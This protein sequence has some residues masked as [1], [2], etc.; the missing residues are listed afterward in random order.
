MTKDR[1]PL[2]QT[3]L[4][5][6]MAM[7]SATIAFSIDAMLPT[8][9]DIGAAL[10][11]VDPNR[12]QLVIG[13]FILGMG[14]GTFFTGP[15]SDAFG[16]KTIAVWGAVIY[17]LAAL[18]GAWAQDLE[19]L[20]IARFIQGI[21]AAGPRVAAMAIVRD[22]FSG[23][24]MAQILSYI[25]FVFTLAPILA[26][27]LGWAIA[28]AFGWRAIFYSFAVFSVVSMAWLI[29]RQ[30]E[31]LRPENVRPFRLGKLVSGTREVLSNRRVVK[32]TIVLTLIFSILFSALLSSQPVF[33]QVLGAG[34]TFP[35]WFGLM[36]LLAAF[37][38][39]INARV[40][41]RFGM[42]AVVQTALLVQGIFTAL[43]LLLQLT[44][45]LPDALVFPLTFLWLT[46]NFY[47]AGFG[48]GNMNA[49]AL[50]PMGHMAGLAASIVTALATIGSAIL[51]APIGQA[52][53]GTTVPLTVGVLV[54]A[55]VAWWLVGKIEDVEPA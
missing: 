19:F 41:L 33:E 4:V 43:F 44:G 40:V 38:N 24:R 18:A 29:L 5:A 23:R 12:A 31:T 42:R 45:L 2:S 55:A 10:S 3:E 20:L 6:L 34:D 35:L 27:S 28:W 49:L 26:P 32:A 52:F 53:N 21:G 36:G 8:L 54:L 50:E 37:A 14:L 22:L 15:L 11:P 17:T 25:I 39:L 30:P 16:R 9:P 48:I 7:L 1:A 13:A 51:S 47:L 46:A